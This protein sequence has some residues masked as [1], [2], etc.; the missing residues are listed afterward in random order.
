MSLKISKNIAFEIANIIASFINRAKIYFSDNTDYIADNVFVEVIEDNVNFAYIIN[1]M[2]SINLDSDKTI[3]KIEYYQI[4]SSS[5]ILTL[6]KD[7][8]TLSLTAG[9]NSL[10]HQLSLSYQVE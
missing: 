4:A 10:S 7:E 6:V 1:I 5:D 2:F 8:M 3:T 9:I